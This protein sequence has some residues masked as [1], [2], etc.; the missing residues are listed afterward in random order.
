[1]RLVTATMKLPVHTLNALPAVGGYGPTALA[2]TAA[3][4]PITTGGALAG[5]VIHV[6]NGRAGSRD[7]YNGR[8]IDKQARLR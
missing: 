1:M 6:K 4:T 3:A 2:S 7:D 5:H 8:H